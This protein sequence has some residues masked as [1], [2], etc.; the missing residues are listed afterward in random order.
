MAP[1]LS[2]KASAPGS[3]MLMGEHAVLYRQPALVMAHEKRITVTLSPRNDEK[4]YINSALGKETFAISSLSETLAVSHP[5]FPFIL[6]AIYRRKNEFNTG[7]ELTIDSEFSHQ[8]GFGSSAALVVA[9]VA[10]LDRFISLPIQSREISSVTPVSSVPS[11]TPDLTVSFLSALFLEAY[12]IIQMVQG[13]G[14]GADLAASLYGGVVYYKA[15]TQ[16]SSLTPVTPPFIEKLPISLPIVAFYSGKKV[17]TAEIIQKIKGRYEKEKILLDPLFNL[18]GETAKAAKVAVEEE[19]YERLGSLMNVQHGLLSALQVSTLALD[20]IVHALREKPGIYGAKIS[21][22]GLG[23][24]V[25]G[26]GEA[27]DLAYGQRIPLATTLEG[28]RY[29]S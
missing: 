5:L 27:E 19:D 21:G 9:L 16:I 7:F 29:E 14:S 17:K 4:I 3:L 25:I 6:T 24:S 18:M 22:A 26:L 23:D 2:Y 10:V 8:I 13:A 20:N 28:L 1:A 15:P 12:Q 11:V